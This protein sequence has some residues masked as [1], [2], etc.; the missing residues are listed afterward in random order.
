MT[1]FPSKG[2]LVDRKK[3]NKEFDHIF[4]DDKK[5]RM[6]WE[7]RL[8]CWYVAVRLIMLVIGEEYEVFY[9]FLKIFFYEK[10]KIIISPF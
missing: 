4:G 10:H 2:P 7:R 6:G 9:C 8:W 1:S 5:G 3:K